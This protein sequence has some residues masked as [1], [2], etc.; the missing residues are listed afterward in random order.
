MFQKAA[1][2][3][4]LEE[5]AVEVKRVANSPTLSNEQKKAFFKKV[6]AE[7]DEIKSDLKA[8]SQAAAYSWGTEANTGGTYTGMSGVTNEGLTNQCL[9]SPT[10]LEPVQL[11]QLTDALRMKVPV[12]LEVGRKGWQAGIEFKSPVTESGLSTALPGIEMPNKY[13][14]FPYEPT[15][16]AAYLPGAAMTEGESARDN[17]DSLTD[18]SRRA[19][20]DIEYC[21]TRFVIERSNTPD[22]RWPGR[23]RGSAKRSS[24]NLSTWRLD[25]SP[26]CSRMD[27]RTAARS[28]SSESMVSRSRMVPK[29]SGSAGARKPAGQAGKSGQLAAFIQ[30]RIRDTYRR[31]RPAPLPCRTAKSPPPIAARTESIG[32]RSR[33]TP[34]MYVLTSATF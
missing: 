29:R 26:P 27:Q 20:A 3:A 33:T 9:Q 23:G 31:Q 11:K 21:T 12:S 1:K 6:E 22:S 28:R 30:Q 32:P 10:M 5:L 19:G 25:G 13:L 4:R 18:S 16:L 2:K 24:S 7:A 34:I 17:C 15:R 8:H 14:S